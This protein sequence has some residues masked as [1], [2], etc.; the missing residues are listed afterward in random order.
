MATV[1]GERMNEREKLLKRIRNKALFRV[2]LAKNAVFI[3]GH[4]TYAHELKKFEVCYELAVMGHDFLT[5]AE[6]RN[7]GGRP[8]IVDLEDGLIIEILAS[9]KPEDVG[10]KAKKYPL[11]IKMVSA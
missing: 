8:D 7:G 11:P 3:N 1:C 4:N 10:E 6:L 5:E 9:E 2:G